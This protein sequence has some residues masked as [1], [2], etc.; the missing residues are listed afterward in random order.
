MSNEKAMIIPGL[1]L[2]GIWVSKSANGGVSNEKS[3]RMVKN[4]F[5]YDVQIMNASAVAVTI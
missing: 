3:D 2:L 4:I 1:L 5:K